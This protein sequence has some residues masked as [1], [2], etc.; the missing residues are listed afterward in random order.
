MQDSTQ[1]CARSFAQNDRSVLADA[2]AIVDGDRDRTYGDPGRNV[3]AIAAFWTDWLRA[4]GVLADGAAVTTDDACAM[5]V[6]LK[7]A[8]L[9]ERIQQSNSD[10]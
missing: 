10:R 6:M 5:M 4:R 3:R 2:A 1:Q 7:L 8:R 9:L